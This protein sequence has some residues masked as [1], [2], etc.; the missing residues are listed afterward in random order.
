M[1]LVIFSTVFNVSCM[2]LK[3]RCVRYCRNFLETK[4]GLSL[5]MNRPETPQAVTSTSSS[6]VYVESD[7]RVCPKSYIMCVRV[8]GGVRKS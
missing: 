2:C 3:I 5:G 1:Q 4:Q 8:C 6:L 7:K